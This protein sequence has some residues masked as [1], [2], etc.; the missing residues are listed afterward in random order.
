MNMRTTYLCAALL[1]LVPGLA[2]AQSATAAMQE[3]GL[4]G[5]WAGECSQDPSPMNNHATYLVTSAGGLQL[6]YQS[7]AD[8]E[9]SVYDIL[10]AKRVAPDKLSLRQ[11]LMSND[12]VTLDIVLLKENDKIR[13][14]SSLFPDGTALVEDGVMTSMTGRET[15]WMTHCP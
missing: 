2:H 8:F 7:G 5:T 9:E 14:W 13:I 3:F 1:V 15:R 4:L 12:R 11:V 10:D 6:K